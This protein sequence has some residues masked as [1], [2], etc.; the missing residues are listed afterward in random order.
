MP[1]FTG[2]GKN[3]QHYVK[4]RVADAIA[5]ADT[6]EHAAE[7][8]MEVLDELRL[9]SYSRRVRVSLMTQLGKAFVVMLENP[10]TS[11]RDIAVRLGI[12]ESGAQRLIT[13][14]LDDGLVERQ[15]RGQGFTYS[16]CYKRVWNHPDVWRFALAIAEISKKEQE[17]TE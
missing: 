17:N 10:N 14:L 8:V 3:Y 7:Y 9:V 15:S 4:K 5:G 1:E 6:L 12:R 11:I 2:Y 13:K 16:P